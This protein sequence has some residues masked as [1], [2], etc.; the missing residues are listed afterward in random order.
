MNGCTVGVRARDTP[1]G[2]S[3]RARGPIAST[4]GSVGCSAH[5]VAKRD[6]LRDSFAW[7][8]VLVAVPAGCGA[9]LALSYL[10]RIILGQGRPELDGV[11]QH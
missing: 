2:R 11:Q 5:G 4:A 3:R 1:Y 7:S 9:L 10:K 6:Q 8:L